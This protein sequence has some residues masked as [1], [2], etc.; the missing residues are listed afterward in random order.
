M[1]TATLL[2]ADRDNLEDLLPLVRS[3]HEFEAIRRS[4][5]ERR[6]ALTPLLGES[7]FGRI[8]MI[9]E[10][11]TPV[12]YAA[13]CFGYS[14]EFGGRDAFVDELYLLASA[15]G[16]GLGRLALTAIRREISRLGVRA[17]HL[18][19][20]RSNRRARR[21]YESVGFVARDRF[22]LMSCRLDGRTAVGH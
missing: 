7:S 14:I 11:G 3:Y 18:E 20:A 10:A 17:L 16:R 22:H 4:D 21:F 19:V 15:R 2:V 12:G 9:I 6:T 13:I 8:W 1:N 5:T